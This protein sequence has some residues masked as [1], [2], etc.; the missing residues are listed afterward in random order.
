MTATAALANDSS[1]AGIAASRRR[2]DVYPD[3]AAYLSVKRGL[4]MVL[5]GL[6][7]VVLL[8]VIVVAALLTRLSSRGPAFY[9]QTRLGLLGRP[10]MIYKIRTMRHDCERLS[11]PRWCTAGDPRVTLLGRLFRA[12]K[13]DELPQLWNV[14]RG[15]MSLI[16]P[17]PERP[18][19]VPRLAS[20]IPHYTDRLHVLP[21]LSGLAQVQLPPDT[22]LESVRR[23]LAC[24]LCYVKH[25]SLALDLKIM[26]A[27]AL[28]LMRCPFVVTRLLLALPGVEMEAALLHNE[29]APAATVSAA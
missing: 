20:A 7:L 11:G 17:R 12:T 15:D 3:N 1:A 19:F 6:L 9:S 18:E 25:V 28:Y 14:L 29:L 23:K 13:V 2:T 8:P 27:T 21:G 4:D 24:D 16:G 5:A 10:F 22:D 26:A